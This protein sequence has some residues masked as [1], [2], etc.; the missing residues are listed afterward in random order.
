LVNAQMC[1][2][3]LWSGHIGE[4]KVNSGIGSNAPCFSLDSAS[5]VIALLAVWWV[6]EGGG[7]GQEETISTTKKLGLL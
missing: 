5:Y 6:V 4:V 3:R 2:S 1:W 7:D